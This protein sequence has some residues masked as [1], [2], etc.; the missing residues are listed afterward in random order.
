M[1]NIPSS[2]TGIAGVYFVAL[3]LTLNG[4][5]ALHTVRNTAGYDLLVSNPK[6]CKHV[7]IQVKTSSKKVGA[8]LLGSNA[9]PPYM[10]GRNSYYVFVRDNGEN[11]FESFVVSG[12]EV[13]RSNKN[14][15][16]RAEYRKTNTWNAWHLPK[17]R[18]GKYRNNWK[19][20]GLG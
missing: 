9:V 6:K 14:H 3:E 15:M 13:Y 1:N 5:I 16:R 17:G 7:F 11:Q 19:K 12:N 2:L 10:R 4:Y 8:W 18:E 20:L